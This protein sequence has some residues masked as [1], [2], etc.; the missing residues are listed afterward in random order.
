MDSSVYSATIVVDGGIDDRISYD[1]I[2]VAWYVL[3]G[4]KEVV[5]RREERTVACGSSRTRLLLAASRFPLVKTVVEKATLTE[6]VL[7]VVFRH[8]PNEDRKFAFCKVLEGFLLGFYVVDERIWVHC[9]VG[10]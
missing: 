9:L 8:A 4:R 1:H 2:V 7:E 5:A 6:I 10:N 3:D